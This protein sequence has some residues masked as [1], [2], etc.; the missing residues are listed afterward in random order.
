MDIEY[1][2]AVA[3]ATL[4]LP[5]IIPQTPIPNIPPPLPTTVYK[6]SLFLHPTLPSL[7]QSSIRTHHVLLL[8]MLLVLYVAVVDS[9]SSKCVF[10]ASCNGFLT[11]THTPP[12][13][14]AHTI[15]YADNTD[16]AHIFL[17]SN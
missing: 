5:S 1:A 10:I 13:T 4:C 8:Q 6:N 7:H 2:T 12:I 17:K 11:H 15:Y 16:T 9:S 14:T 3:A